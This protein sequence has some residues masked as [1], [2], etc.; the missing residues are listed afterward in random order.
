MLTVRIDWPY[1]GNIFEFPFWMYVC[2][3][4]YVY[5]TKALF[6]QNSKL[7]EQTG[8]NWFVADQ[9]L[10]FWISIFLNEIF[11]ISYLYTLKIIEVY[12]IAPHDSFKVKLYFA[13]KSIVG[14][15]FTLETPFGNATWK[16]YLEKNHL[17]TF[18][19]MWLGIRSK[20]LVTYFMVYVKLNVYVI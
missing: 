20:A 16:D 17:E 7:L 8:S 12:S 13:Q 3:Y 1:L 4:V 19:K 11:T 18:C 2:M 14:M 6:I 9:N 10:N 15:I 5:Q